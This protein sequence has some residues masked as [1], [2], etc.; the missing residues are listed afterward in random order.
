[1]VLENGRIAETDSPEELK[2]QNALFARMVERQM[3]KEM[4]QEL[5]I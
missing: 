4:P 1:V 5:I 3:E 2:K